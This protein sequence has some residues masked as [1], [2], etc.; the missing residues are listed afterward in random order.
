MVDPR[1]RPGR[2]RKPTVAWL[3]DWA[4]GVLLGIVAVLITLG[5]VHVLVA[6]GP[7]KPH[8]SVTASMVAW[9]IGAALGVWLG[10]GPPLR[11]GVWLSAQLAAALGAAVLLSPI[12]LGLESAPLRGLA[13]VAAA[14]L[15]P[16]CARVGLG[17][18]RR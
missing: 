1:F 6:S 8:V 5:L 13:G 16:A 17:L 11:L 9:P 3:L 12:F 10:A 15:V 4:A 18:T 14:I 7:G 2:R